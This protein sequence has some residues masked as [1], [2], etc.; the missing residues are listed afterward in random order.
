MASEEPDE[1]TP[2]KDLKSRDKWIAHFI[3]EMD[4]SAKKMPRDIQ[5]YAEGNPAFFEANFYLF[6]PRH[7]QRIKAMMP[8][9]E[10]YEGSN[11]EYPFEDDGS[12]GLEA[13]AGSTFTAQNADHK[14]A[15]RPIEAKV[16]GVEFAGWLYR[17]GW[18]YRPLASEPGL[19][20]ASMA[21]VLTPELRDRIKV[22]VED[23]VSRG[24]KIDAPDELASVEQFFESSIEEGTYEDGVRFTRFEPV[25]LQC[26]GVGAGANPPKWII[27]EF[28]KAL[29]IDK[30]AKFTVDVPTGF[31]MSYKDLQNVPED[32]VGYVDVEH[33]DFCVIHGFLH[34]RERLWQEGEEE[35]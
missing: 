7:R 23:S 35:E 10:D 27:E 34:N 28:R 3:R 26:S 29:G 15:V 25:C 5:D 12:T 1:P 21:P 22:A 9:K 18:P 14:V 31:F 4:E 30:K 32:Y 8:S 6:P 16:R 2:L 19:V 33:E 24:Y 17:G 13:R 20:W 11:R